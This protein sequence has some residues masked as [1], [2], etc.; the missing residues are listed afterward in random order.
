[1]RTPEGEVKDAV[2]LWLETEGAYFFMPVQWGMGK[3]SID[4]LVC[5]DGIF[6]GIETKREGE[7]PTTAQWL[8]LSDIAKA[9]GVA[10]WGW[11]AELIQHTVKQVAGYH[12]PVI[13]GCTNLVTTREPLAR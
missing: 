7:E 13:Y 10:V 6:V 4:F 3:R 2:K 9:G 1:M 8:T 11:N 5:L 12:R